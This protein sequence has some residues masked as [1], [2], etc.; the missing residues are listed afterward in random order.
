[1]TKEEFT[2]AVDAYLAHV[3]AK[4]LRGWDLWRDNN[5]GSKSN[6]QLR[7]EI[8]D[9]CADVVGWAF[10]IWLRARSRSC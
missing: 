8:Q 2:R 6:D 1:M 3:R 5:A 10:W 9:E 7:A 4:L